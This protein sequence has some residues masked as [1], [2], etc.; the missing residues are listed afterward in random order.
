MSIHTNAPGP[1]YVYDIEGDGEF[2]LPNV[3]ELLDNIIKVLTC[4]NTKEMKELKR[5]DEA[6]YTEA[7]EMKF[8][9]FSFRYYGV[10]L[11]VISG[12][13]ITILLE[14]IR[15]IERAKSGKVKIEDVEKEVGKRLADKFVTK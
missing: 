11:K 9:D 15:Q 5:I 6:K 10:F 3:P 2:N 12:E 7:M 14:M 8:P 13:D 1:G 4:M